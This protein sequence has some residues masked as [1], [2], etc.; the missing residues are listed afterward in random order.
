MQEVRKMQDKDIVTTYIEKYADLKQIINADD[1]KKEAERQLNIVKVA[2][3]TMGVP[4]TKLDEG[5]KT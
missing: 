4:T 3:E 2:L 1:P 5:D